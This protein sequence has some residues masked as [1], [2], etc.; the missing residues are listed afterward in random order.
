MTDRQNN[1]RSALVNM[2]AYF[3]ERARHYRFAAATTK[4]R[5]EIERFCEIAAMFER[6]AHETRRSQLSSRFTAE[7]RQG[8]Q[9]SSILGRAVGIIRTW[10]GKSIRSC[11]SPDLRG[12]MSSALEARLCQV[13]GSKRAEC[14]H[15]DQEAEKRKS[16]G[17]GQVPYS[18]DPQSDG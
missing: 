15:E 11:R 18:A 17:E 16:V 14:Q 4:N 12:S 5:Y 1:S 2:T 8:D 13:L 6:M 10:V 9:W 3:L 7:I